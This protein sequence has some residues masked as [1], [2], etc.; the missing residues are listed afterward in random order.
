[1]AEIWLTLF[2]RTIS[3]RDHRRVPVCL[4]YACYVYDVKF[5]EFW[6]R[7]LQEFSMQIWKVAHRLCNRAVV[8]T[9]ILALVGAQATMTRA[10]GVAS[11]DPTFGPNSRDLA[12]PTPIKHVIIIIGENRTFDNVYATYQPKAGE[13]VWNLLSEGII[14]ADGTPGPNYSKARQ[15]N[16]TDTGVFQL[17]PPSTPYTT[18]P[19]FQAGGPYTPY[20]CRLLGIANG[21][22]TNC[23]TPANVAAVAKYENGLAADYYQYLLT[24]GTGQKSS[25][26]TTA[27]LVPDARVW[28][29][30]QDASHLPPGPFQITQKAHSP[31]L[32][33]DAY[34]ASPVHRLFQMWQELGCSAGNVTATDPSGCSDN[35]FPWVEST[36]AA[37]SNGA[38]QPPNYIGEGSTA[39]FFYN[40]QAGDAPY[41]KSLADVY[42]MS[43]NYH[44]AVLGGTGANHIMMGSGDAIW[45]SNGAGAPAVPPNNPVDPTNPGTP[46]PGHASALSEIENPDPMPKTNNFYTED[47]YGGGSGS[48][49]ATA[50]NANHGGGS[51]VNCADPAQHGVGAVTSYLAAQ[52]PGIKPNCEAGHY[53]LVNNYN[54]GY[55]G[56]GRNAYTD[57]NPKNYV[58]TV[59][60]SNV[61]NIGIELSEN[62]ISWAYFG[63]QFNLYL[64][65]PYQANPA[66]AYCNICNWAAYNTAIMTNAQSRTQH[67][68]DTTDLYA[69]IA[70][71]DLPAVSW[72]KPSGLVDGHPGSSKL[73]L[74]E[75]FVKKIVD[76]VQA[77][78]ALAKDTAILVTLDEGG[79]SYDSGYVQQLDFFGDGTRTCMIVV[80][81]FSQGGHVKHTYTDHVSTLKFIEANWGLS[82]VTTRS[83]DNLPNPVATPTNPYVPTN[84]PAIG[85]LMD[86]F[87]FGQQ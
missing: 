78:P 31:F 63:D 64:N 81:R 5:R 7:E 39:M 38:A 47:G 72:V 21:T 84:R 34:T 48:P 50:P 27:T 19:P 65:D 18:L 20:G 2:Y 73:N 3:T 52:K 28:Y 54:P 17:A 66:D 71:G 80:S 44:Q 8:T 29:D 49:A 55:F 9:T 23:N 57:T 12:T 6:K 46:L 67:L 70:S 1:M 35:L 22:T 56:D 41:L 87:N 40:V 37:G 76:G 69:G 16:A 85:D 24:G 75:G 25:G 77:N 4:I 32:P 74:F 61:R 45:F 83:R 60:P 59:P 53:Y 62:N 14:K 82:P 26:N 10:A 15:S 42:T 36:V 43:D 86:M 13:T 79:G 58:F 51:Y 11:S 30:G 68:H 33:Y